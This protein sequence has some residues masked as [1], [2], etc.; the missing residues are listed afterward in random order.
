MPSMISGVSHLP[1]RPA[2]RFGSDDENKANRHQPIDKRKLIKDVQPVDEQYA[3]LLGKLLKVRIMNLI[4]NDKRF[5]GLKVDVNLRAKSNQVFVTVPKGQA[6]KLA[7]LLDAVNGVTAKK[8]VTDTERG[9]YDF[10][11]TNEADEQALHIVADQ[12]VPRIKPAN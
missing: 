9:H 5:Q 7:Q 2:V 1:I 10:A 3:L 4:S 6:D 12:N 8:P 11:G